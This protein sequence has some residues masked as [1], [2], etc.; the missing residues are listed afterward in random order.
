MK[1]LY[2]CQGRRREKLESC[3][4]GALEKWIDAFSGFTVGFCIHVNGE[5]VTCCQLELGKYLADVST[6]WSSRH[7]PVETSANYF[8][9][10][11]W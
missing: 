1:A 8:P 7:A 5:R 4:V 6:E 3:S 11:S 2:N 10:S 9:S